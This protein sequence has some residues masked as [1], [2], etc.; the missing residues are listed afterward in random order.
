MTLNTTKN[1]VPWTLVA[2]VGAIVLVA[3]TKLVRGTDVRAKILELAAAELGTRDPI[4]YWRAVTPDEATAQSSVAG[5]LA[6]CGVFALWALKSAGLTNA[7]W[8]FGLGFIS[9][10]GL[11][12]TRDPQPGDIGYIDQPYQHHA[13]VESVSGDTIAS[14][15]GNQPAVA[16]RTRKRSAFTAFYSIEPLVKR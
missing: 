9:P 3:L 8:V 6:W 7:N 16:R 1:N 12:P 2:G 4:K 10:L 15:D 11:K 5:K 14:I 13:I